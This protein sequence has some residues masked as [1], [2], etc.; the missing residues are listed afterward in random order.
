[1]KEKVGSNPPLP[2]CTVIELS[3]PV[4]KFALAVE[5]YKPVPQL[6]L[7]YDGPGWLFP[8]DSLSESAG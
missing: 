4:P 1:M 5:L 8:A 7:V 2:L 6:A 3:E